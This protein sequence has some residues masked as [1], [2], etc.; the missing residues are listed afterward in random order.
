MIFLDGHFLPADQATIS[1]NDR[2]FLFGDGIFT[3]LKVENGKAIFFE[4]HIERLQ[5][6]CREIHIIPP[7]IDYSW[8]E[9][10]IELKDAYEGIWRLK[11]I[12]TGGQSPTTG[13]HERQHGSILITLESVVVTDNP[14]TAGIFPRAISWPYSKIKTLAYL[15]R[16]A[17][18]QHAQD[19]GWDDCIVLSPEGYILEA[20]F[21]NIFWIHD[22]NFYTPAPSLPLLFGISVQ[23]AAEQAERNG[24]TVHYV[25]ST[26]EDIPAGA[27]TYLISSVKGTRRCYIKN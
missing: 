11:I 24:L 4:R 27:E 8:I 26:P 9:K 21:A 25:K 16:M 17:I 12:I 2:G 5:E 23:E 15:H 6:H 10:L 1:I 14:V 3:T 22:N 20:S 18:I 7:E 13:L 19:N